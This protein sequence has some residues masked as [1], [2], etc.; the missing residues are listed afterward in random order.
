MSMYTV[1]LQ[2]LSQEFKLEI[3]HQSSDFEKIQIT[4]EDVNRPALQLSG[5]F[6]H[7][8]PVRI[9]VI[10]LVETTYLS[11]LSPEQRVAAFDRL[12]S[13]RPPALIY[14]R[15]LEPYEECM[16]MA[17]K[18]NISI[19]RTQETT[20]ELVSTLIAALKHYLA[21]RQTL[22]GVLVE[23]HGEGM[24]LLGES[25]VGKSEAAI[26]L[27][28][29]GHRIIADD[30]VEI[31]KENAYTIS[32]SAPEL[33]RHYIELRGIGV[34]NV[35]KLFGM[36][37]IKETA[38]VDMVV[39]L[40]SWKDD[41]IYDRLGVESE[42]TT[43]LGVK[44]PTIT[45]PVKPGRNLAVILEVAAMNNRQKKMGY[46]AALEFTQQIEQYMDATSHVDE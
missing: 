27:V 39:N 34:I 37:A 12:L 10:G 26:E 9:Q 32:G 25:G 35:A 14:A 29:R 11:G 23:V 44:V 19:L 46:N 20:S 21:P 6:E 41:V 45:I 1:S 13:Y 4:V 22:H 43:Y 18:Y 17:K 2:N 38:T 40:E 16:I 36:G 42:F 31:K 7:F 28:K 3:L 30:A 33:I 15:G 24:L 5:F 8:E